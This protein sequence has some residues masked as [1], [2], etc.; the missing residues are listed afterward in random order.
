[1]ELIDRKPVDERFIGRILTTKTTV[2]GML[3][4]LVPI[5]L[6][7][8]GLVLTIEAYRCGFEQRAPLRGLLPLTPFGAG[9]LIVVGMATSAVSFYWILRDMSLLGDWYLWR[10]AHREIKSRDGRIVDPD[11]PEAAFAQIVPRANWN[12]STLES[13]TDVGF[14]LIDDARREVLF[15]GDRERIRI[16]ATGILACK[17]F[18]VRKSVNQMLSIRKFY[19]VVTCVHP[20]DLIELPFAHRDGSGAI[21]ANRRMRRAVEWRDRILGLISPSV[22][23]AASSSPHRA[24]LNIDADAAGSPRDATVLQ[25]V[26]ANRLMDLC[27]QYWDWLGQPRTG[28]I[29][30]AADVKERYHEY[31]V[32]VNELSARGPEI[33][34]WACSR[35]AHVEYDARE[36]TAYLIGEVAKGH[37]LGDRLDTV[38]DALCQLAIRPVSLDPKEAQSNH[39]AVMALGKIGDRKAVSALRHVLTSAE[40]EGH[41]IQWDAA[42]A[43]GN[44]VGEP[45]TDDENSILSAREWLNSHPTG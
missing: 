15:E 34:D 43:L 20:V 16:P 36:Q 5:F 37:P 2:I 45:F 39:A 35:L 7:F 41:D 29:D 24:R 19:F 1:M 31:V 33:L 32:A 23:N 13:A 25:D 26:P 3:L 10:L 8:V 6:F 17:S 44:V 28:P 27:D 38:V 42:E 14:L 18:G 30:G 4:S 40:W 12:R 9:L 11:N 22:A 21:G